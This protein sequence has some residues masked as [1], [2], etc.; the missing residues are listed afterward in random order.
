VPRFQ[1]ALQLGL[2]V[3]C[4]CGATGASPDPDTDR[5]AARPV[6]AASRP[7]VASDLDGDG[8]RDA[9]DR[10]PREPEDCDGF[11]DADGC[12]D[13]DNDR[14]RI[15]DDQDE[16]P[17]AGETYNGAEDEDGCPDQ[18]AI[19]H[20][21]GPLVILEKITFA[22][23]SSRLPPGADALV[24]T[25][26]GQMTASAWERLAIVGHASSDE[27]AAAQLALTRA[28]AVRRRMIRRG[29]EP[30]RV[31]VHAEVT[32]A[33]R[34]D[35]GDHG[36]FVAFYIERLDGRE[37]FRWTGDRMEQVVAGAEF[38]VRKTATPPARSPRPLLGQ[39]CSAR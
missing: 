9:D 29:I 12:P 7:A 11:A 1:V 38:R 20:L 28:E 34:A 8:V 14:D 39:P 18:A 33:S 3:S 21:E 35:P 10:C 6:A 5:A 2:A 36:R 30:A 25:I 17:D 16:C 19:V 15:A 22:R 37:Q 13:A 26:H 23:A 27:P 32:A 24:G 4:G 31:V